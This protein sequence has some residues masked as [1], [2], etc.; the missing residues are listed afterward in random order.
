MRSLIA[1]LL[2]FLSLSACAHLTVQRS[3]V[4]GCH[5]AGREI[6]GHAFVWGFVPGP[7]PPP[8]SVLCPKS[9][10]GTVSLMRNSADVWL[11]IVT[12]GIYVPHR[13]VVA[14]TRPD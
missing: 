9:K 7:Q 11:S 2:L 10:I 4:V 3:E 5:E 14:C 6:K 12:F 1:L 8:E 13:I